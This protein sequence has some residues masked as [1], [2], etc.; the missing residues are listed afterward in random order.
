MELLET[1]QGPQMN[2]II[3]ESTTHN[4]RGDDFN[5]NRHITKIN[6]LI[7]IPY[8]ET[9]QLWIENH[10]PSPSPPIALLLESSIVLELKPLPDA[11]TDTFLVIPNQEAQLVNILKHIKKLLD[12]ISLN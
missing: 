9:T 6:D 12:G 8:F 10:E 2:N 5:V 4:F 11:S 7:E 3:E 1:S